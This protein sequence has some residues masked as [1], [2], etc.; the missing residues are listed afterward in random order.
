MLLEA[1]WIKRTS[2]EA[3]APD[4]EPPVADGELV[5]RHRAGDAAAMAELVGRHEAAIRRQIE[6]G[7]PAAVRR[8]LAPDDVLQE[9]WIVVARRIAE[10]E[11]RGAG[12]FRA[13]ASAIA[14]HKLREALRREAGADCRDADREVTRGARP[15]TAAFV[16][17]DPTPS[18]HAVANELADAVRR[19]SDQLRPDDREILRL[20]QTEGLP[21]TEAAARTGRSR[22]AARKL[23][24]RALERF[25]R[26]VA[27]E[28][29][30]P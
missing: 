22:E 10:F 6:R 18:A 5:R 20:V 8:R 21:L 19:A 29:G 4:G 7:L 30:R 13:W 16:A 28:Q 14:S 25:A 3:P 2:V 17:R 27:E 24:E 1:P 11:D 26:L 12:A 23:Y 9:T 15:D